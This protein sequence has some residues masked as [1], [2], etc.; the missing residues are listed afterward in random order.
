MKMVH[1]FCCSLIKT[2]IGDFESVH[3]RLAVYTHSA[4]KMV[5]GAINSPDSQEV[6]FHQ[7]GDGTHSN[8]CVAL[9]LM[10]SDTRLRRSPTEYPQSLLILCGAWAYV[11][12]IGSLG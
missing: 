4:W 3:G 2:Q 5:G 12:Q 6:S 9:W 10:G 11:D 7:G 8:S 1:A